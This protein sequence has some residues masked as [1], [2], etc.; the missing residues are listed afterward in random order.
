MLE[1]LATIASTLKSIS[2]KAA[3]IT[4]IACGILLA[5]PP[6]MLSTLGLVNFVDSARPYLG[7]GLVTSVAILAA[8]GLWWAGTQV[9]KITASKAALRVHRN[10]LK[11]LTPEERAYL[12]PYIEGQMNTL[13]FRLDDGIAMGLVAKE[14]L[15]RSAPVGYEIRGW[16][17]NMHP[18]AR[19]HLSSNRHL[20]DGA[21]KPPEMLP[22]GRGS[23]YD[24]L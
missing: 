5:L 4:A 17:H 6:A 9:L 20:L 8:L 12:L 11:E 18:W 16:A 23:V 14:I 7:A 13:Y 19:R 21:G 15:F 24:N 10:H 22:G 3:A 2:P 1:H